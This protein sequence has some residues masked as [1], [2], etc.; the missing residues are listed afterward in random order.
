MPPPGGY[1]G[2]FATVLVE[3]AVIGPGKE[4]GT[5]WDPGFGSIPSKVFNDLSNALAETDPVAAVLVVLSEPLLTQAIDAT[6]KPDIYGTLRLDGLGMIGTEY[7]L[8]ERDLRTEDSFTP[9]FP[10]P[11]GYQ[12]VPIDADVRLRIHLLD[13]DALDADDE[14]GTFVVNGAAMRAALLAQTKYEVRVAD[15]TT[16]QVLFVGI[17]VLQE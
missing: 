16:N 1:T 14:V 13:A 7:W 3:D 10:G 2:R 6:Q 17:S 9:A 4:D 5:T 8:A 12:Q 15:Q 11:V